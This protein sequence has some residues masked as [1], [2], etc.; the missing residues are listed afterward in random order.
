MGCVVVDHIGAKGA[1]ELSDRGIGEICFQH[2]GT[3]RDV[4][5][6]AGTEVAYDGDFVARRQ[7]EVG[8]VQADKSGSARDENLHRIAL[9][10]ERLDRSPTPKPPPPL[11]QRERASSPGAQQV[12]ADVRG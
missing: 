10:R 12:W 3:G 7:Q 4:L 1:D 2:P 9:R 5:T 8:D 6:L 11:S